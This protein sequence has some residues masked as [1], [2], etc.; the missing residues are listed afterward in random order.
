MQMLVFVLNKIEV[1]D[2][3]MLELN[4]AGIKGATIIH[5]SGMA[6]ALANH[7]NDRFIGSLRAYL[8]P[9]REENRTIFMILSEEKISV[10]KNIIYSV[11]GDLSQPETGILFTLPTLIVEG[12]SEY[13]EF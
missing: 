8:N 5:S 3:L 13:H 7:E 1:L 2:T 4:H 11:V 9:D 6:K 10:A 12:L